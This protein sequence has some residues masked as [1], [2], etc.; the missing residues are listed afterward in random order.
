MIHKTNIYQIEYEKYLFFRRIK[1]FLISFF[2]CLTAALCMKILTR[3]TELIKNYSPTPDD[4]FKYTINEDGTAS[5]T[6]ISGEFSTK[7]PEGNV[8]IPG[9]VKYNGTDYTVTTIGNKAFKDNTTIISVTGDSIEKLEFFYG[10]AF[11]G[12]HN[13]TTVTL[14]NATSIGDFAFEYCSQLTTVT[15]PNANSIEYGAFYDCTSLATVTLPKVTYIGNGA[16]GYCTSLATVTLP[17][18]TSIGGSAFESCRQLTTVTLPKVTYIGNGAFE[19]CRKLTTVTLPKATSIGGNAFNNCTSLLTVT[20]PNGDFVYKID[21]TD[22]TAK[23]MEYKGNEDEV[24]IIPTKVTFANI[25]EKINGEYTLATDNITGGFEF[26]FDNNGNA[27]VKKYNG[28]EEYVTIPEKALKKTSETDGQIT[29]TVHAVTTIGREAFYGNN[30]I[31]SVTSNS[32]KELGSF[33][34]FECT[35]LTIVTLPNATSI[36]DHAF[37]YCSQLTTVTLP[38]A[39]SIE[40]TAFY[41]CTS[42]ATVILPNATSIGDYAFADCTSLA[43]VTLPKATYIGNGAFESCR[44]L[45]TVTLPKVTRVQDHAFYSCLNLQ[46]MIFI[47][48][49]IEFEYNGKE[50]KPT[51]EIRNVKTNGYDYTVGDT[52]FQEN[53]DY[54]LTYEN[55]LIN[56]GSKSVIV[57]FISNKLK[58]I[59]SVTLDFKINPTDISDL[60]VE[61]E[62]ETE[63]TYD[64]KKWEPVITVKD[65]ETLVTSDEYTVEFPDD[66]TNAGEKTVTIKASENNYTGSKTIDLTINKKDISE[67]EVEVQGGTELTYDGQEWKPSFKIQEFNYTLT[68]NDYDYPQNVN[69]TDAG[70]KNVTITIKDSVQNY[71]GSRTINNLK[72]NPKN[73]S[74]L[75]V[76]VDGGTEHTYDGKKW[77]PVITVKDGE[78]LVTSDEYTAEFPDDMTNAGGKT[79]IITIKD[80][81]QN[82]TGSRTINNLKINPKNISDL[83]V[84]VEGEKEHTYD[85]QEWKPNF[86]IKYGEINYTLT[87]N[88][89]D[90][91]QDVNMIDAGEKI[92]TITVKDDVQNYTGSKTINNLK[93]NPKNATNFDVEYEKVHIYDARQP[94]LKIKDGEKE[95]VLGMDYKIISDDIKEIGTHNVKIQYI[96]NYTG[97]KDIQLEIVVDKSDWGGKINNNGVL[98]YVDSHGKTSAEVT[99]NETI[100]LKESSDG[101]SAWYAVDNSNGTFKKG[102][103]FWVQWLSP[104][105]N[106]E[107]FEKYY[108][109]LDDKHKKQVENNK[110]WIFLTGVTDPDGNDYTNLG[111]TVNYYIQLGDDWDEDDVKAAFISDQN[112]DV[113][114]VLFEDVNTPE[115]TCKFAKILMKHFSPYAV[116]DIINITLP[117]TVPKNSDN[118]KN[119]LINPTKENFEQTIK[120]GLIAK[121]SVLIFLILIPLALIFNKLTKKSKINKD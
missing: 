59:G 54:K 20:L 35:S 116:Y 80:N 106:K 93:I 21:L 50:Q 83:T 115:G 1:I 103:R 97:E 119:F 47:T 46:A 51:F 6:G 36:G 29:A 42:L 66:M 3:S 60:T 18:A 102:S 104:E 8:V 67:L 12:C 100:W 82:Y 71:T 75:T 2:L 7:F 45:T 114:Q 79:A 14:P 107:E 78:T 11:E 70:D 88:D 113:L 101:T 17:K 91:P 117:D 22:K 48:N 99:G 24:I 56:V 4:G 38:N 89:Y 94:E 90:Y 65:G 28:N 74:E 111:G 72:I 13:L 108:N 86:K 26:S 25:H 61:V 76:E 81:V 77:E 110:L 87:E 32:I 64:G 19:S 40:Y 121:I 15:L 55:D 112:D 58:N 10:G 9:T 109:K 44:Q 27:T 31:K 23:I 53:I 16:F 41:D 63:H 34:F 43:T 30:S 5:V 92:V 96:A 52:I 105:A 68:G 49:S 69:M 39:N 95:L 62:G 98:N 33:A 85:G 118:S 84:E 120:S 73:I 37:E 57:E